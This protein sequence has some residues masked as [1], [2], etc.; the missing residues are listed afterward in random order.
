MKF[1]TFLKTVSRSLK[2]AL[3]PPEFLVIQAFSENAIFGMVIPSY[4]GIRKI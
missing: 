3:Q 1:L 4:T 2:Q